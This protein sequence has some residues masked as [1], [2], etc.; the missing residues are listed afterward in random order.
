[1]SLTLDLLVAIATLVL[2]VT[3][4]FLIFGLLHVVNLAN[5]GLMAVGV[6]AEVSFRGHGVGFWPSLVLA[7][8]V[9]GAVGAVIE[10]IVIRR[11]YARPLDTILAT[12]GVSLV[13]VQGITEIYGP[14]Q[15]FLNL[16]T[17]KATDVFGTPYSNYRLIIIGFGAG[18]IAALAIVV[19]FTSLGLTIRAVMANE[20]LA[21]AD[22]IN[23]VR[24][25]QL[26]FITGAALAGLAGAVLGPIEGV[27]PNFGATLIATGFLAVLLSGRTL[28]GLVL[29]CVLL[30]GTMTLFSR[31]ENAVWSNVVVIGI[32]VVILRFRPQ[33]LAL[34]R[35][36]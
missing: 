28:V 27:D 31:Y 9:T 36:A 6:Y 8:L 29:S 25:R 1:V 17:I 15:R 21:R 19:R 10:L 33:G 13:L 5:A 2:V 22:G 23:T 7:A 11:L 18:L 35:S 16:P 34:R 26:T 32:A 20:A 24:V 4:L 14:G 12:W 30:A 3:G